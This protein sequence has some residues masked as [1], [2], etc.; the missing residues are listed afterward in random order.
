MT[1]CAFINKAEGCFGPLRQAQ[2][3]H[4]HEKCTGSHELTF[5]LVTYDSNCYVNATI[6]FFQCCKI[7][8]SKNMSF[9]KI[10]ICQNYIRG[11]KPDKHEPCIGKPVKFTIRKR[12]TGYELYQL[13]TSL[14]WVKYTYSKTIII[15]QIG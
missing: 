12:T 7:K 15:K 11:V 14:K 1:P 9:F 8:N 3:H 5:R 6:L 10:A 2:S 13:Q 4:K